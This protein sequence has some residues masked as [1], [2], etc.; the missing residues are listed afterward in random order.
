V[1]TARGGNLESVMCEGELLKKSLEEKLLRKEKR[2]RRKQA[3]RALRF[4]QQRGWRRCLCDWL[5]RQHRKIKN[6]A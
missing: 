4:K 6:M 5:G 2:L 3:E 1:F